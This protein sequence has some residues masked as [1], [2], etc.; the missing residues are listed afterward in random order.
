MVVHVCISISFKVKALLLNKFVVSLLYIRSFPKRGKG[1]VGV[2]AQ[3]LSA[4]CSCREPTMGPQRPH[5]GSQPFT[6]PI[7]VNLMS[8]SD[9][10]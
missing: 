2:M 10:H 5:G 6:N 1:W 7:A 3:G 8:P 9:P 4:Y